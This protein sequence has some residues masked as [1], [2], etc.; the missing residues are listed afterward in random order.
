MTDKSYSENGNEFVPKADSSRVTNHTDGKIKP[1]QTKGKVDDAEL[2]YE[3]IDESAVELLT[4]AFKEGYS[5]E[6][7]QKRTLPQYKEMMSLMAEKGFHEE[8]LTKAY[9]DGSPKVKTLKDFMYIA[10]VESIEKFLKSAIE[11]NN[12][13][14]K[15]QEGK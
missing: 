3:P 15:S 6:P 10:P 1:V 5:I 13:E 14:L 9:G 4:Q 8:L 7:N 2:V 11:V 12:T